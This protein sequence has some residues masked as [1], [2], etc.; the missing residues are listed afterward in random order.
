MAQIVSDSDFVIV[1]PLCAVPLNKD[2]TFSVTLSIDTRIEVASWV[3]PLT[4]RAHP[5]L[6][7]DTTVTDSYGVKGI[8]YPYLTGQDTVWSAPNGIRS[9]KVDPDSQT[10]LIGFVAF[11]DPQAPTYGRLPVC[12]IH[13]RITPTA[14][15]A[16]VPIDTAFIPPFNV[17]SFYSDTEYYPQFV[18]GTIS[19]DADT[20]GD[21]FVDTCDICPDD[22]NPLQEDTDLDGVGDA[23]DICPD[24]YDPAQSDG[25]GD[26]VGDACDNCPGISNAGQE[27]ADGD[28]AGDLCDLC[29]DTDGDGWGDPGYPA[30]TC[31]L[32]LCPNDPDPSNGDSD[33]DG[34]GNACDNCAQIANPLQTDTDGDDWGD[35]CDN[36]PEVANPSQLDDDNNGIGNACQMAPKDTVNIDVL[37]D[38]SN[39]GLTQAAAFMIVTDP[40][41]D[42]IGPGF[43]TIGQGGT[44]PLYRSFMGNGAIGIYD[45]TTDVNGD[46]VPD[47]RVII[48]NGVA[49]EYNTRLEPRPGTP[50]SAKFT[51]SVRIDGNQALEPI[52]YQ[53]ATIASLGTTIP[54]SVPYTACAILTGDVNAD[55]VF[56]ASDIIYLV[57]F[58]FKSGPPPLFSGTGDVNCNDAVTSADI[59]Y[60]VN[61]VFKSALSPCS[62]S[63]E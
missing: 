30:N 57:N 1:E 63:C 2:T 44:P 8:T 56:T 18:V 13:F 52:G 42:S 23:C 36:C 40:V 11:G 4:Y 33:E 32:D 16:V 61:F 53:S 51:L 35:P 27:D 31:G 55:G 37:T 20:D 12:D 24:D 48:I 28:G 3:I 19:I 10:I 43:N 47:D 29:T 21:G 45:T 5:N 60:M 34:I 22:F 49:G 14:T 41:G 9:S 25:D 59:I 46:G 39:I 6:S 38:S 26:G 54:Q 50:D 58:V 62:Q 15:K 17:L 7:I